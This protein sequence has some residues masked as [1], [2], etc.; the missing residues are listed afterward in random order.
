MRSSRSQTTRTLTIM[1]TH[2]LA[3]PN[4]HHEYEVL[5]VLVAE[6]VLTRARAQLTKN[7]T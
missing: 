2:E 6:E 7:G 3:H 5:A 4:L 1:G